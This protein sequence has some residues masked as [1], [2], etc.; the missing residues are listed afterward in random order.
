MLHTF[1]GSFTLFYGKFITKLS[2]KIGAFVHW[3]QSE[4]SRPARAN[5]AL[6]YC[7]VGASTF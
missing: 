4:G 7:D 5:N 3:W 6:H 1:F 2:L